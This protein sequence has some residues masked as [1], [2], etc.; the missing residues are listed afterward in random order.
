MS[1][2]KVTNRPIVIK[3]GTSS[4]LNGETGCL[5]LGTVSHVVET[6]VE[7]KRSGRNVVL[8][9]SGSVGFG[10][11]ALEDKAPK[12]PTLSQRR[13][14][15][16]IGQARLMA[17]YDDMFT[18]QKV[19]CAQVLLTYSNLGIEAQ[20]RSSRQTFQSLFSMG[21]IPI[22]NENDPVA[23]AYTKFGDNDT[24]SAMIAILVSAEKL[25]LLT[26]VD[27]LY[28]FFLSKHISY[29]FFF[30][31]LCTFIYLSSRTLPSSGK[32]ISP[33][34]IPGTPQIQA[35]IQVQRK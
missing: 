23:D 28:V 8:V 33:T 34:H 22:V 29:Y 35:S 12:K 13:A 32:C 18:S 2:E 4:L 17:V 3:I 19:K 14:L 26:D 1:E 25:Y 27:G 11:L 24:L 20:Y 16:A 15:A 30:L 10:R 6:V 9:T 5:S 21:V 7:L 31:Y